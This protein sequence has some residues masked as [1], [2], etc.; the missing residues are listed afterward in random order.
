MQ[1]LETRFFALVLFFIWEKPYLEPEMRPCARA[2]A[3]TFSS[4]CF[5]VEIALRHFLSS[6]QHVLNQL[7]YDLPHEAV[8]SWAR[9]EA[10]KYL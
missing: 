4:V 9:T 3:S 8:Y 6:K 7:L 10:C 5:S 2:F 1:K